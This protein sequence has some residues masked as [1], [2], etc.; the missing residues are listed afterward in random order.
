MMTGDLAANDKTGGEAG[1]VQ[2]RYQWP[3]P[4]CAITAA[5]HR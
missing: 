2:A 5:C 3:G 4:E 1:G